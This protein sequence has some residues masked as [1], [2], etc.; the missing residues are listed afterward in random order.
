V[1]PALGEFLL[2]LVPIAKGNDGMHYEAVFN[3]VLDQ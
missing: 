3:L 1:Q 2:F